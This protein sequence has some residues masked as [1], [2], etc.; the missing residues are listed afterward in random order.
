V[1]YVAL[2]IVVLA[3][4]RKVASGG[5]N[6]FRAWGRLVPR[7]SRPAQRTIFD[8]LWG[9]VAILIGLVFIAVGLMFATGL[10]GR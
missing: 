4:H 8:D 6:W 1:V 5:A 2:G 10:I 7:Y 3:L 9:G